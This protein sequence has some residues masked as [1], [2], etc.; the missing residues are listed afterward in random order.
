[1]QAW[2][3][4]SSQI[5]SPIRKYES[6]VAGIEALRAHHCDFI[7]AAGG[8]SAMDV[9]KCIKL[10]LRWIC[11]RIVWSRRS[12]KMQCHCW[13]FRLRPEPEARQPVLQ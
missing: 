5:F 1:M 13:R 8:G 9:A 10:F 6:V 3:V 12:W 7:I 11:Q 2:A 4:Q